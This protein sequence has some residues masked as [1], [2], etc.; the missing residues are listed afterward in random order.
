LGFGTGL[1]LSLCHAIATS[2][3]G[4]LSVTSVPSKGSTFRVRL[5]P[6][7]PRQPQ[8]DAARRPPV[9]GGRVLLVDDDPMVADAIRR[10]LVADRHEV[11]LT[12]NAEEALQRLRGGERFEAVICDL[13][14]PRAASTQLLERISREMP[15]LTR[16][17]VIVRAGPLPRGGAEETGALGAQI[18]EKPFGLDQLRE[19]L[20]RCLD[21]T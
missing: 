2:H 16:R 8:P 19:S 21:R 9:A 1:G 12:A 6:A 4:E 13:A 18:L 14:T 20:R 11:L 10:I 3:G 7:G 17:V 15:E 5:P